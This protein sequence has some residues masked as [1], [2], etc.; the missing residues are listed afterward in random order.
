MADET[1]PGSGDHTTTE[2]HEIPTSKVA[3]DPATGGDILVAAMRAAGVDTAFGVI[4][5]HNIPLVEAVD[6][7]L[8]FVPVRHEAAAINAADGYARATG[9]VGVAI[10]ST[11]TGA[12]NAAGAMLEA[13]TA[14]SRVLHITGNIDSSF[15]GEGRGVYHEVPE[16]LNM[17]EAV[18]QH[19]LRIAKP[20]QVEHVLAEA[21]QL[22]AGNPPGPVSIDW[23]IDLQYKADPGQ[24]R[25]PRLSDPTVASP[26][27]REIARAVKVM[28]KAKRPLIWVGGG[29]KEVGPA[30]TQLAEAWRAGVL[31]GAAGRGSFPEDHPLC[32]GNFAATDEVVPLLKRAD[33]LLTIGSHLRSNETQNFDLPLPG[34]HVQI[35]LDADAIGRNFSVAAG[36]KADAALAV[37]ELLRALGSVRTRSDWAEE[38]A[39]AAAKAREAH[40]ADIGAYA[41]ICDAMR[42]RLPREAPLVRDVTIPG[43][44]WGNRLLEVYD[45]QCNIFAAGG[46]IG[47]GLA[48]AIGAAA[49]RL[50]TPVLALVGDG[51]LVVHLGELATLA[52]EQSPVILAVFN[53]AG[54]GVLRHMQQAKDSPHRAVD[55]RTPD[56][57]LLARSLSLP[58]T[59]VESADAFDRALGA[60]LERG[61]PALIE[62]KVDSLSPQPKPF[63]P[64]VN[65]P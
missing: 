26:S 4:S 54:Y 32:L 41:A 24:Q 30:L 19:V 55:L 48:M 16:Q 64:P 63:V 14:G 42:N 6:R 13:L 52:Q 43:S 56:F 28:R 46:G 20:R 31:S 25:A 38:V 29:A 21:M 59:L 62:I 11:G 27:S 2:A 17:L 22:L 23:P 12:G 58:H 45:P 49:G 33:C 18:S 8:R 47:Q 3:N 9:R 1:T 50:D 57:A 44:S 60:A 53:D 15:L 36:I 10:T 37:P 61:G 35:D 65:V 40:R 34:K 7:D 5:I 51:G 39:D